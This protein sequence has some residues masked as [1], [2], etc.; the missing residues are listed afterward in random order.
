MPNDSSSDSDRRRFLGAS[1]IAAL[2]G[3]IASGSADAQHA[4]E[5][6]ETDYDQTPLL[7]GQLPLVL[8]PSRTALLL[9]D[10]QSYFVEQTSTFARSWEK[11]FPGST[12]RYFERVNSVVIPNCVKLIETFR[13]TKSPIIYTA[14]GSLRADGQDLPRW[15]RSHNQMSKKATG[16][17]MYPHIDD[18]SADIA[19]RLA[20]MEREQVLPKN[21]CG[22]VSSS[23]LDRVLRTLNIES[24][25]VCG[26]V[27]DVCVWGTARELADE[28]FNVAIAEDACASLSDEVHHAALRNFSVVFGHVR[29]TEATIRILSA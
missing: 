12:L 11:I 16:A 13:A 25:V 26:V 29:S 15:A 27:T 10:M 14:F 8:D 7:D 28:D 20:P 6:T 9:I 4:Q 21:T 23:N 19:S 2:G 5:P 1:G 18:P 3:L 17:P 22:A 24:V